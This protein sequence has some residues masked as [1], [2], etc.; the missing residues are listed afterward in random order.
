MQKEGWGILNKTFKVDQ[1]MLFSLASNLE[2]N[3]EIG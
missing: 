2:T 1:L 3:T